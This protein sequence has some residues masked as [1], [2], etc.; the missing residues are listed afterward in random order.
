[1]TLQTLDANKTITSVQSSIAF[2]VYQL[3]LQKYRIS[4]ENILPFSTP[5]VGISITRSQ[6]HSAP[7]SGTYSITIGNTKIGIWGG[8][9]FNITD[10]PFSTNSWAIQDSIQNYYN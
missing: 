8:S 10:I 3:E 6:S 5:S 4:S 2:Y 7:I 1:V 9:S